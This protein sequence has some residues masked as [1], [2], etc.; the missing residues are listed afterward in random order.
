MATDITGEC[1]GVIEY[2]G[3]MLRLCRTYC[4]MVRGRVKGRNGRDQGGFG[5]N[6]HVEMGRG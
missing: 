5:R 6:K 2:L 3:G 1:R 4:G